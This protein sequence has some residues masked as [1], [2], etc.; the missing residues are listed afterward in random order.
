MSTTKAAPNLNIISRLLSDQS[1]TKKAYL[2]ALASGLDY[3]ARLLVGFILTPWL[4]AGLG[5]YSY[6]LWQILNRVVGY[7]TPA[8]GRPAFALKWTLANQ[9]VSTDYEQKRRY[10]GSTL[11]VWAIFL[12]LVAAIGG[13]LAWFMPY[14]IKNVPAE[15]VWQV[16][17]VS[18]LLVAHVITESLATVPLSVLQGENLGY[19]RMGTSAILV[20]LGGGLTWL[21]LDLGTGIIGVA[22]AVL[23]TSLITGVFFLF[24]VRTYAPW[25]G[26]ARPSVEI[27]RRFLGLSGWFMGWNL[28]MSLMMASDVVL[29][30]MLDSVESVTTYTL[31]KYVPE[32]LISLVAI[33]VFGVA[34]GLGG[35]IGS[36]MLEKAAKIRSE[37][38]ALTWLVGTVLGTTILLWNRAFLTLW[39]GEEYSAGPM[40]TLLIVVVVMQLV[41]IRNDANIIDLTLDLRRKVIV[42]ALSVVFVIVF[43]GVL[44]GY[45]KYGIEG[46]CLGILAGRSILSLGYPVLVG[47]LLKVPLSSQL[48]SVVRPSL[49]TILIFLLANGLGSRT[50]AMVGSGLPG[51]I[52]LVLS[53]GLTS[54][55]AIFAAFY[56]GLSGD[57]RR[58]ILRRIRIVTNLPS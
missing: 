37:I 49:V 30:G 16:R 14:W 11:L 45:F 2:N 18:G 21:A 26:V 40:A 33:M 17:I 55:A 28:V 53:F 31:T 58:G 7:I 20:L 22:S 44:V 39:V 4:V 1:L 46:L 13:A 34:P 5:A 42:G 15:Y 41:L 32:T 36:G 50:V 48:K 56:A 57:Q 52:G 27:T 23:A 25:F 51:W 3:T 43:A 35:I 54:I 24:V 38:M 19:K 8:S 29:L 9:Q 10:V 47:R 12:P 6:G